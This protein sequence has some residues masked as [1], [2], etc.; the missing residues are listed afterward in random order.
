[1]GVAKLVY[2]DAE[3]KGPDAFSKQQELFAQQAG[4]PI[5]IVREGLA[6]YE[7]EIIAARFT[8]LVSWKAAIGDTQYRSGVAM[9]MSVEKTSQ[10][11]AENNSC[12]V[13]VQKA[14]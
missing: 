3:A 5:N 10:F 6:F 9:L 4:L 14:H 7:S 13:K 11:G 1:L 12:C 2:E 8:R